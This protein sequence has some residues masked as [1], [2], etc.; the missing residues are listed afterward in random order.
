MPFFQSDEERK[1]RLEDKVKDLKIRCFL[2][3][4]P[5]SAQHCRRS[6]VVSSYFQDGCFQLGGTWSVGMDLYC[7]IN[8][9]K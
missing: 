5:L 1:S 9:D 3:S 6:D 8:P 2:P 7:R 4:L